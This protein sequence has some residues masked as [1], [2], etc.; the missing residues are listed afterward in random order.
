MSWGVP[1]RP[2][3]SSKLSHPNP[4]EGSD[5]DMQILNTGY[6]AKLFGKLS[7][8][9]YS[10]PLFDGNELFSIKD[11]NG[12][13]KIRINPD[14]G[15][16]IQLM[17]GNVGIGTDVPATL[18][19]ISGGDL[20]IAKPDND[21]ETAL[22]FKNLYSKTAIIADGDS[23]WGTSDLRFCLDNT[24]DASTVTT[25][26]TRMIITREGNV[27]IAMTPGG[28]HKIDVTGTA[29]LS[30]STAWTNTSDSR[31]KKNIQTITG[32]LDKINALRP[33]SFNY[34][35]EYLD[36]HPELSKSRKY[37]SF[38][39]EEYE[40]VFPDAV[41]SDGKLGEDTIIY[42]DLKQ[43]NPHDLFM[44]VAKAIQEL[45]AKI[46]TMQTEINNLKQ[47]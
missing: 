29:G 39:A 14:K 41:T 42:S 20:T 28:S 1:R 36:H 15:H 13:A 7:G 34:T 33:V 12:V 4:R 8:R 37:N 35:N 26:D 30:T 47:G 11:K 5:G 45:S 31:I 46:D 16:T 32:G 24:G 25:A 38:I 27:G 19:E 2:K 23:N 6:G 3:I 9:W 17:A 10:T 21:S 43:F 40:T 18:L 22:Y 44:Y